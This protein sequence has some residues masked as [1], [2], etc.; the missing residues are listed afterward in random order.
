MR[1]ATSWREPL[2]SFS[3]SLPPPLPR[4]EDAA[5]EEEAEEEEE[6]EEE[7]EVPDYDNL[8]KAE[9]Q[10]LCENRALD[11]SGKPK[12]LR[13]R[14]KDYDDEKAATKKAA[15]KAKAAKAAAAKASCPASDGADRTRARHRPFV[16][17]PLA[18]TSASPLR[19]L[20]SRPC[21]SDPR[22]PLARQGRTP[23]RRAPPRARP[24]RRP[25]TPS[26][27]SRS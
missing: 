26:W 1:R 11:D 20:T 18:A 5:E 24:S 6:E 12:E 15:K 7:E 2:T 8:E 22:P 16:S 4:A 17:L 10:E 27:T 23:R 3:P 25:T 19:P 14:L 21:L 13:K 9:L